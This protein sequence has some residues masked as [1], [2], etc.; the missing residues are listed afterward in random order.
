MTMIEILSLS[1]SLSLFCYT[2]IQSL[3]MI[4]CTYFIYIVRRRE[5]FIKSEN[6]LCK[7]RGNKKTEAECLDLRESAR[8]KERIIWYAYEQNK[9]Q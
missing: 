4:Y 8:T 1:L 3:L 5:F 7:A 2:L 9:H 6:L